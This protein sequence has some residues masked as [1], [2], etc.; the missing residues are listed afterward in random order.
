M[1]V[2]AILPVRGRADQTIATI[3]RLLATADYDDWTLIAVGGHDERETLMR[4]STETRVPTW[5]VLVEPRL[6]Y[7]QSLHEVTQAK[8]RTGLICNLASDLIPGA[9]WL[10]RGV[11][12]YQG[13]FK[14]GGL[15][16]FNG[17][18]HKADHSC[19]FLIGYELLQQ[20]G[21]WP[22]WYDH[23][24]GDTELCAR[25]QELGVYAKA[26]WALLFHDHPYFGG[27]DDE[28]YAEGRKQLSRDEQLFVE[29]RRRGWK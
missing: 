6:T 24:F 26:P 11:E 23:N 20:L 17:D 14:D 7:W 10:R 25:T 28:V 27:Q 3:K 8:V 1:Q 15:L 9:S 18:S 22:V 19:H 13:A 2:T 12:A 4:V 29:R 5:C 21:G 16:G